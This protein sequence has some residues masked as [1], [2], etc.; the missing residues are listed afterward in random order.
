MEDQA[1]AF[2][3]Q[4]D[5][6][7]LPA[8]EDSPVGRERVRQVAKRDAG[9]VTNDPLVVHP[10]E[11]PCPVLRVANKTARQREPHRHAGLCGGL[12]VKHQSAVRKVDVKVPEPLVYPGLD[13]HVGELSLSEL[14]ED[15]VNLTSGDLLS[16][17]ARDEPDSR[18]LVTSSTDERDGFHE[19]AAGMCPDGSTLYLGSFYTLKRKQAASHVVED[20]NGMPVERVDLVA[21]LQQGHNRVR[22]SFS[23]PVLEWVD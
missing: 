23:R 12:C 4:D 3:V 13:E 21:D 18:S 17:T 20:F 10:D 9:R 1:P 19:Q 16:V 2:V 22:I 6:R 5:R 8:V 15:Q 11:I 7:K 14:F